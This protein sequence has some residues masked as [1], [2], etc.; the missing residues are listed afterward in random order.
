[1]ILLLLYLW[2]T[3]ALVVVVAGLA[4]YYY[5]SGRAAQRE[6]GELRR[7]THRRIAA[8]LADPGEPPREGWQD[9]VLEQADAEAPTV[10]FARDTVVVD[11]D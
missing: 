6:I 2:P 8:A 9:R 11:V 7:A 10:P 5:R 4:V 1:V 3:A